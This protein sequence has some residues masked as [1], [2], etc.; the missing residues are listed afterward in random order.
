M[1]ERMSELKMSTAEL[2]RQT[3]LSQTTIR[4]IGEP[5]GRHNKVALVAISA[6][7]RWR[8]D[9]LTNILRGEPE[10]NVRIAPPVRVVVERVVRDEIG[11][12]KEQVSDLAE[13]LKV[14]SKAKGGRCRRKTIASREKCAPRS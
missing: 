11:P 1:R 9:H 12:L 3:G 8:Y 2:A 4:Y 5:A 14:I 7:L 6:V 10:K 13:T